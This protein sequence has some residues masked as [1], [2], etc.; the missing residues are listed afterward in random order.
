MEERNLRKTRTGVVVSD[1]MNKTIVVAVRD[2]VRHPLYKKI[3]KKTYK[4]KA[5]DEENQCKVG[6]TVK[7][8]ETRPLSK[9]KRWRLVEIVERAK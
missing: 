3:V 7:V 6:D 5:H 4:L 1:K 9:D 2:N 8:M